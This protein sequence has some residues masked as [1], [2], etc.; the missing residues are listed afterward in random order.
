M[1]PEKT[2]AELIVQ[3]QLDAY[4][5]RDLNLFLSCYTSEI[6][7]FNFEDQTSVISGI[8]NLRE[9]YTEIFDNSPNL[10]ATI[11]TRII[12]DNKVIDE[13]EVTGKNGGEYLKV[14]AIYEV[15]SHLISKVTFIRKKS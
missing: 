15:E 1:T 4:N 14:I 2:P 5:A 6:E 8:E 9:I 10:N 12:F 13:E 11:K 3:K 7:I